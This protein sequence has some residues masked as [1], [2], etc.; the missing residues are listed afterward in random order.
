M[1]RI[2]FVTTFCPHYRQRTFE[3]LSSYHGIDFLFFSAGKEW[4]WQDEHGVRTGQ[5]SYAYLKGFSI[6]RTRVVPTMPFKLWR[7]EYD[8]YIKCI[9]GRFALPITFLVARFRRKPFILWTGVWS[10]LQTPAHRLFFPITRY[11]LSHADAVVVYGDHVKRYV[12]SLG[13][14]EH[15]IFVAHHAVDND[16]FSQEVADEDRESLRREL[17]ISQSQRII[18]FLGRL[19][20][21]KGLSYL[22][23]AFASLQRDDIVL[24]FAGTGP[25]RPLLE[26]L[27][28]EKNVADKVR[29]S[30]HVS[31]EEVPKF[32]ST[33]SVLV[34]PSITTPV[35]KEPWGLVINEAFNQGVPVIV[36]A[37]V[38]AAAGGLVRDGVNGFIVPERDSNGLAQA[39]ERLLGE[40]DLRTRMSH[41]ARQIISGWNNE[42]MVTGFCQ[43]INYVQ[44]N[45]HIVT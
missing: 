19:V 23:D 41:E 43:A 15:K 40:P 21:E 22:L 31:Q 30:G 29:F 18:L 12:A 2:A 4:Y 5:F 16:A 3:I 45:K 20:V 36:T 32:Y 34:L 27:S 28:R 38:G 8:I 24:L 42:Q 14:G 37:A 13:V 9:N 10:D 1:A 6:G 35:F 39:L 44:G 25:E 11:I 26:Q 17:G 33:A 7:R